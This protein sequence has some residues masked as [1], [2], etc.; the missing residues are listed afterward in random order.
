MQRKLFLN[1]VVTLV[2]HAKLAVLLFHC[3]FC[4]SCN[5]NFPFMSLIRLFLAQ[6][7]PS[8]SGVTYYDSY[9]FWL[10]LTN[11]SSFKC[12]HLD[13]YQAI[14]NFSFCQFKVDATWFWVIGGIFSVETKHWTGNIFQFVDREAVPFEAEKNYPPSPPTSPTLCAVQSTLARVKWIEF[15]LKL[16][17]S[18]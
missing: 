1:L 10:I 7:K 11:L 16:R 4:I 14:L 8:L 15:R 13:M 2:F 6:I 3:Y 9:R 12:P 17:F 18:N 5:Y